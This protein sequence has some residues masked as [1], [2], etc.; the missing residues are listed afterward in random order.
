VPLKIDSN[1]AFGARVEQRLRDE[2][3]I[4]MV[5]VDSNGTPQPSPVWFYWDADDGSFVIY[6]RT[7]TSR[8]RNVQRNPRVSLS[9]NTD[10]DGENVVVFTGDATID[11]S[12]PPPH[13]HAQYAAKYRAGFTAIGTTPEQ[14]SQDYPLPIVVRP[15]RVR[16]F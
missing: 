9:F 5:T 1:T 15:T 2:Q 11:T 3:V 8:E 7:G 6:S 16:G 13:A 12:Q 10:P 4:W 14:F